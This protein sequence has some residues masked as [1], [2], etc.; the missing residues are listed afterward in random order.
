MTES[1]L[2]D[3]PNV[4]SAKSSLKNHSVEI[5]GDFGNKT[6]EQIV[7]ELT[8]PLKSHG[9][10]VSIE[11]QQHV[12]KWSDFKVAL[13]IAV[14]FAVLFIILQKLGIVNLVNSENITYG[15]VFMIGIIASL[16]TCMAVVGGL[17]L[18]MSATFAKEG[19]RVRPQLMFHIGRIVSFF[20]LGGVIGMIGS[21]FTL[22]TSA[23]FILSLIIGIVMLIL[24]INLLGVFPWA[25]KLQPSIPKFIAKHAHGVSKLNHS[26][27][28]LLLGVA[29]FFLPCGFTQ[30]MQIFTLSTGNFLQ[31]G[32]TMLSFALGTLPV[33]ALVS[34]SSFSIKDSSKKGIFFKSAGLIVI[35]FALFNLLNSLVVIGFLPPI[36]NF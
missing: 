12:A 13:P 27:T 3:L 35:M 7:E 6:P 29:T 18:S 14:G 5:V 2:K 10:T 11:K 20:I 32:L 28:P 15:T 31:G 34:F 1:E 21:A 16:S 19:E 9:Y 17:V 4:T 25:K 24:G 8:I 30:S 36:F 33:L 26:V 22:N 23:T